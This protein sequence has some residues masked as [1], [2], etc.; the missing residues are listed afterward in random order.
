[1]E[2]REYECSVSPRVCM[3]FNDIPRKIKRYQHL[4]LY[5]GFERNGKSEQ[6]KTHQYSFY[7]Q[8]HKNMSCKS[9]APLT[10]SGTHN[11]KKISASRSQYQ[12][13]ILRV[14]NSITTPLSIHIKP[15]YRSWGTYQVFPET[16][17]NF[18]S[19]LTLHK[20]AVPLESMM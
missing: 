15:G 20:A 18:K 19:L 7:T 11:R 10:R 2:R 6:I 1:M 16:N 13:N 17:L 4:N 14:L 9:Q 5:E 8:I 3:R 12:P